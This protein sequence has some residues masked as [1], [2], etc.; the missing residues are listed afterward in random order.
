MTCGIYQIINNINGNGYIGQS[1]NIEKRWLAHKESKENYPL[2]KAFRKYGVENFTF[3]ILEECSTEDLNKKEKF[4]IET[5]HSEYNQ[6]EGGDYQTVPQKLGN[7]TWK[8]IQLILLE[9][10][11]GKISHKEL[12]KKYEVHKDTIRDINMGRT[13]YDSNFDYP[14]HRSKFDPA[15]SNNKIKT[16]IC[17]KCGRIKS[18]KSKV[19]RECYNSFLEERKLQKEIEKEQKQLEKQKRKEEQNKKKQE[20]NRLK[21]QQ[22]DKNG[23]V[24]NEFRSTVDAARYL[25][26]NGIASNKSESGIRSHIAETCKGKRKSAYGYLWKYLDN[27]DSSGQT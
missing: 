14:L 6:T 8:E 5:E 26:E 21:Y 25:I 12:A 20:K 2:Y 1:R 17:P 27:K 10:K 3:Q 4:Y 11:E 18:K 9:D 19:C 16:S 24:I 13:W 22:I 23:K 15:N 7:E